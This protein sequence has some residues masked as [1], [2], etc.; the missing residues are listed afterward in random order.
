MKNQIKHS[1]P[2]YILLFAFL[3]SIPLQGQKKEDAFFI[4]SIH[5]SILGEG[6]CYTWLYHLSEEIGGR[7]AGSPQATKA[8][9]YTKELL[10]KLS[11]GN[12]RLQACKTK[13][14]V[15]GQKE[16]VA[17]VHQDGSQTPLRA[18]SLG[19]TIGTGPGGVSGEVI[20]VFGLDEL[21]SLGIDK[22]KGKIVFFNR[23]MDNSQIRTF[24][25]Y[26][27]AVD[28]RWSGPARAHKYGAKATIVRSMTTLIDTFPHTGSCSFK[29]GD[30]QIP[31]LAISTV[32]AELLSKQMKAGPLRLYI[33]NHAHWAGDKTDYNV[34]SEIK[35]SEFP[36]EIIL[37]GGHLDSWDVG[38]GAHDDGAG[39]VQAMQVFETLKRLNYQPKRTLRC[40]LFMNEENGMSG[41][42]EYARIS[43]K[44]AEQHMAAI[45]SDRGG[46]TPR[47]FLFEAVDSVF[48]DKY[49]QV[50]PW[51]ELLE[52]YGLYFSP[53]GSGADISKLKSQ[54][55]LLIGFDPDSQRYFDFHHTD[56]DRISAVNE[57]ELKLGAAAI[58]SLVYL[59]DKYGLK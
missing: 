26:G 14:W 42:K 39:C 28:Q 29:Q 18:L 47:G 13:Y 53:G 20:E 25:A 9:H 10:E 46:F 17:I 40:V 48:I 44:N 41:A 33:E 32:D 4:K 43:N 27:A 19:N 31:A 2:V 57:R 51:G 15:R 58:T 37:V 12:V 35:G 22:V 30:P 38:G 23:P 50:I 34:I 36:D 54:A 56:K 11:W 5:N 24:T 8:S 6:S 3:V 52:P 45:E 21:D 16:K 49:R 59:L 55:G 1:N 7:L